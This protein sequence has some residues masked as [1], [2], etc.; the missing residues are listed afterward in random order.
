MVSRPPKLGGIRWRTVSLAMRNE[1]SV[2]SRTALPAFRIST[3]ATTRHSAMLTVQASA[4]ASRR[5]GRRRGSQPAADPASARV[6]A[7]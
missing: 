6:C 7:A 5:I 4:N 2:S 3:A 1:D